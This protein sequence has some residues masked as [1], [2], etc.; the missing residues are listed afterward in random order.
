MILSELRLGLSALIDG[1]RFG[2]QI[3]VGPRELLICDGHV[4]RHRHDGSP[5]DFAQIC[6]LN[7]TGDFDVR[8]RDVRSR[9]AD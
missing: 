3:R 1:E 9:N 6:E 4:I 7:D 8:L 2:Q 5:T